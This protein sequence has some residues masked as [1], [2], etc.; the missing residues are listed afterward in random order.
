VTYIYGDSLGC[1][2]SASVTVLV[3]ACVSVPEIGS[4][5][6]I[7]IIPN[8]SNANESLVIQIKQQGDIQV[9]VFDAIGKVVH[10]SAHTV[11]DSIDL[12]MSIGRSG[13]YLVRIT[14]VDGSQRTARFT[15]R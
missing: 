12:P 13:M 5:S 8:P 4:L 2:D 14:E 15:I 10:Q 6:G 3:D 11:I 9:E 7:T 1:V